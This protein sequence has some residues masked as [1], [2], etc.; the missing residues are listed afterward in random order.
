[1]ILPVLPILL[2][3]GSAL[4]FPDACPR[5]KAVGGIF[6]KAVGQRPGGCRF[7]LRPGRPQVNRRE[8]KTLTGA[9]A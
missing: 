5:A 2:A 3:A 8:P 4:L 9:E 6:G 1:M 7:P